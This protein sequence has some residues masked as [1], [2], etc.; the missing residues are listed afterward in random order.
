MR[1]VNIAKQKYII[2]KIKVINYLY[3]NETGAFLNTLDKRIL[4]MS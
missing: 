4:G 3:K 1:V 2:T